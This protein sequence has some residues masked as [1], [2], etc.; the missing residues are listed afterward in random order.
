MSRSPQPADLDRADPAAVPSVTRRTEVLTGSTG[1]A[2]VGAW[3]LVA[4][5]FA[6]PADVLA[7]ILQ[8][9]VGVGALAVAALPGAR[10]SPVCHRAVAIAAL[11]MAIV[12][13]AL[14]TG[15]AQGNLL[16]SGFVIAVLSILAARALLS[17]RGTQRGGSA[18]LHRASGDRGTR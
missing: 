12:G 14:S 4:L 15:F 2:L 7:G 3:L 6:P 8:G 16:F 17:A 13:G 9:G 5:V 18:G 10:R 11:A 1:G